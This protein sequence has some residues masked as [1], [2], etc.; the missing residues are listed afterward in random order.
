MQ[1]IEKTDQESK[2]PGSP[3]AKEAGCLCPVMDNC[4]GQGIF[5]SRG[6]FVISERCPLHG[7]VLREP[8]PERIDT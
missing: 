6:Q 2:S 1:R 3:E 8:L 5:G 7:K 4:R